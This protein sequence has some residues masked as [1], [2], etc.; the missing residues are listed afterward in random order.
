MSSLHGFCKQRMVFCG[1]YFSLCKKKVFEYVP[2]SRNIPM[3]CDAVCNKLNKCGHLCTRFCHAED[4]TSETIKCQMKCNKTRSCNH[5]CLYS[6]HTDSAE[7]TED[8]SCGATVTS[9]C[10]CGLISIK[11]KCNQT[12][13]KL[14]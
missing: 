6:C 1:N 2:C 4:C 10:K 13:Q 3:N 11:N 12:K 7:C 9:K 14:V 8:K 5:I